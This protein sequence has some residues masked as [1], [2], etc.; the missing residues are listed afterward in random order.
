MTYRL[1]VRRPHSAWTHICNAD[2]MLDLLLYCARRLF[3]DGY[4][5]RLEDAAGRLVLA[6]DATA[7][8]GGRRL[9]AAGRVTL[10]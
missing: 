5:V 3:A 2:L 10:H 7:R 1:F 9:L 4:S 8:D 6:L